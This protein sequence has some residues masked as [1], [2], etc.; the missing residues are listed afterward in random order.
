MM[1]PLPHTPSPFTDPTQ[2]TFKSKTVSPR[3]GSI[4]AQAGISLGG[5]SYTS[6]LPVSVAVS[7]CTPFSYMIKS[8]L[9]L[10]REIVCD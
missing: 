4:D 10:A 5:A 7:R 9:Q 1:F 2:L 3:F 8:G 6:P